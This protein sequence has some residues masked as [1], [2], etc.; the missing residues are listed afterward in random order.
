M[1]GGDT[2]QNLILTDTVTFVDASNAANTVTFLNVSSGGDAS[3]D[4]GV[5]MTYGYGKITNFQYTIVLDPSAG[6][7]T[8]TT[9][10]GLAA[11]ADASKVLGIRWLIDY[12]APTGAN[13]DDIFFTVEFP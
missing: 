3:T 5:T 2:G 12:M 10:A 7:W 9:T 13:L 11:S 4:S 6:D 1:N 8:D